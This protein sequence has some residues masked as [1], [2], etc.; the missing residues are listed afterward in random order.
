MIHNDSCS[1]SV[2]VMWYLAPPELAIRTY[3][4][5][6][7]RVNSSPLKPDEDN[8]EVIVVSIS[9]DLSL[10]LLCIGHIMMYS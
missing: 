7:R 10:I 9:I 2:D 8:A 6:L 5:A 4:V 3:V 1:H